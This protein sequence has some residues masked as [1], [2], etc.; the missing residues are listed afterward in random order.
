MLSRGTGRL[1]RV[2]VRNV[3]RPVPFLRILP[4]CVVQ[5]KWWK[6]GDI[7]IEN[8]NLVATPANL[9][10]YTPPFLFRIGGHFEI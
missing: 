5:R 9:T 4:E 7:V 8:V 1:D 3:D 10:D 6:F 2:V